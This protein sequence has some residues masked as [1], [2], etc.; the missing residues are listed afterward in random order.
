MNGPYYSNRKRLTTP[1]EMIFE[2]VGSLQ[3]C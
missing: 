2:V 3:D 1:N